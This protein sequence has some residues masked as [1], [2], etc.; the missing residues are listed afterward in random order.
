MLMPAVAI[1]HIAAQNRDAVAPL[2]LLHSGGDVLLPT[3]CRSILAGAFRGRLFNLYGPAETSTACTAYEV[4]A[5]SADAPSVPIGRPYAGFRLYVLDKDGRPVSDGMPGELHVGGAGVARGYLNRPEL[6]SQRFVPD[7]FAGGGG[8]MYATGDRVVRR[9]DGVLEY[10]G[11]FDT[12][13]K[14]RGYRVEPGEVERLMC[15]DERVREAAVVAVGSAGARRLVAFLVVTGNLRLREWRQWLLSQVP[16]YLVP[17]E[18][19]MVRALPTDAHGER[20]WRELS[21]L[22]HDRERRRA[23]Y[24]APADDLERYLAGLWEDDLLASTSACC[25]RTRSV[26]YCW[27]QGPAHPPPQP[28]QVAAAGRAHRA[29][30]RPGNRRL[31]RGQGGKRAGG[32]TARRTPAHDRAGHP[33][34]DRPALSG[35]P[36]HHATPTSTSA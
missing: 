15:R 31:A 36:S 21:R 7:P 28:E 24:V 33:R 35:H 17:S 11:R 30:R 14:I 12:Q 13:V 22:A 34:A 18:F 19:V 10:L 20:D 2:R 32:R 26:T 27:R 4:T 8:R 9:P 3:A 23:G 6:T 1:N 25:K 29:G 5:L 16:D